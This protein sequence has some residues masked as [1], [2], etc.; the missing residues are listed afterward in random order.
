M[1][2]LGNRPRNFEAKLHKAAELIHRDIGKAKIQRML[3]KQFGHALGDNVFTDL[4]RGMANVPIELRDEKRLKHRSMVLKV[5]EDRKNGVVVQPA[6][7]RGNPA[8][9]ADRV[10]ALIRRG[11]FVKKI[12]KIIRAE[13][14]MG[15][16]NGTISKIRIEMGAS[17]LS[18]KPSIRV[19]PLR[20]IARARTIAAIPLKSTSLHS[21]NLESLGVAGEIIN[22]AM[23]ANAK[24]AIKMEGNLVVGMEISK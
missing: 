2:K 18:P 11:V 6:P 1:G 4:K 7:V 22:A 5:L 14:G 23:A 9:V 15:I 10:R 16:S 12:R 8:H 13:F 24:V 19:R 17:I 20:Q 3:K 21:N